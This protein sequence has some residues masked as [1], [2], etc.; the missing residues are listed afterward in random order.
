M[1]DKKVLVVGSGGREHALC[2]KLEQ[3]PQV[4]KV[5][6]AP[7]N[8][9]MTDVAE[10]VAVDFTD[11]EKL[12]AFAKAKSIDLVV[13]GQEAASEAGLADA[14][15]TENIAVFGP[16]KAAAMIETSKVFSKKL[17]EKANIPTAAFETFSDADEAREFAY[18]RPR[19]VVIKADGLAVGKGVVIA[20]TNE[21]I[22]EAIKTIM[23]DK[24]FGDSGNSVV[25]E[26]FLKGQ[27]VSTHAFCDGRTAILFPVSQD[28]KQIYDGDK[29]PN[30]GGMG[31]IAPVPWVNDFHM[32]ITQNTIVQ[33]ALEQLAKDDVQFIGTLYPGLMIDGNDVQLLEFNSRFGDPECEVYMRL[34]EGDLYQ[35]L[36]NCATKQLSESDVSWSNKSAATVILASAGY[37]QSSH[38]G[39]VISGL[40][41]ATALDDVVVFH[42]GTKKSGENFV[43]NGGR[44]LA[45]TA[46]GDT[47]EQALEK[48]YQAV[49]KISFDGMQFRTDIGRRSDPTHVA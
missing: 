5:Y 18:S 12:I 17:M 27:E 9:G 44:V 40:E 2:W 8:D 33:P 37:P 6:C 1:G 46:I 34:F 35:T 3:S 26:D 42:A 11:V 45:V 32:N 47:L 36:Y 14:C 49:D 39:D 22:D 13:I 29:G 24:Q 7:G 20:S 19:P 38:K 23:I 43:T 10:P 48:T 15:H 28:H 25:I 21:E 30:T 31:V 41:E 4:E 16:T